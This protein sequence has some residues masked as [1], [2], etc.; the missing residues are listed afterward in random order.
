MAGLRWGTML[1]AA[2]KTGTDLY[3]KMYEW[4]KAERERKAWEDEQALK[5]SIQGL[6]PDATVQS[7]LGT[8]VTDA[9]GQEMYANPAA[10]QFARDE[11]ANVQVGAAP[12]QYRQVVAGGRALGAGN[13][14]PE[15]AAAQVSGYNDTLAQ[16]RIGLAA[17]AGN[18]PAMAAYQAAG[19]YGTQ[20]KLGEAQLEAAGYSNAEHARADKWAKEYADAS[21]DPVAALQKLYN[22]NEFW[23]GKGEHAG[24]NV[25]VV[26]HT[27]GSATVRFV[28]KEATMGE[29]GAEIPAGT[30]VG[31]PTSIS[32]PQAKSMLADSYMERLNSIS[33]TYAMH[34]A[35]RLDKKAFQDKQ[36]ALE[37]EKNRIT[38]AFHTATT[39]NQ[40]THFANEL[41]KIEQEGKKW[42][43]LYG[44]KQPQ[45]ELYS[46]Q[47]DQQKKFD[48]A[49][50]GILTKLQ[51]GDLTEAE[52][53][54]QLRFASVKFGAAG[55]SLGAAA[56]P[57]SADPYVDSLAK[58]LG[59]GHITPQ[60]YQEEMSKYQILK[61]VTDAGGPPPKGAAAA[62]GLGGKPSTPV[63]T[64]DI[65][66]GSLA[67]EL[68][69]KKKLAEAAAA[70]G[71][72]PGLVQILRQ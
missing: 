59:G 4:D 35:T 51:A 48:T 52:A 3:G 28:T 5:A 36:L 38:E 20:K 25:E 1:G 27:D 16:R 62:P 64:G 29:N 26:K 39:D 67:A 71:S 10:A 2:A 41:L 50:E 44:Q 17:Q 33:P 70:P 19:L 11:G 68:L 8:K 37:A 65:Q 46:Y 54:K 21:K 22:N 34:N 58:A 12:E 60:Q 24:Q 42:Q 6:G 53:D 31:E 9:T 43:A 23:A 32:A 7:G 66:P 63:F 56:K 13:L 30:P 69:R 57:A 72:I 49:K 14:T 61:G 40:K 45:Q 47:L 15:D 55:T 18:F